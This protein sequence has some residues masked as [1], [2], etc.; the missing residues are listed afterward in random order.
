MKI[1]NPTNLFNLGRAFV[2][3]NRP[4]L[5]LGASVV[6]T[7][8]GVLLAAVGGYK[9]GYDIAERDIKLQ[10]VGEEKLDR[11]TIA[12]LTWMNYLPA[13]GLTASALGSTVGLHVIHVKEKKQL[14]TMALMA[15]E[16]VRNDAANYKQEVLESVG[17]SPSEDTKDLDKATKKSGIA[18]AVNRSGELEEMF[19]VRDR[20][21]GR[22]I[23]SNRLRIEDAINNVNR[24]L[25]RNEAVDLN[26]FYGYA[27][28]ESIPDGDELGWNPGVDVEVK[29]IKESDIRDDGRPSRPFRL[30][31]EP[32]DNYDAAH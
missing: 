24:Q 25:A 19:L 11:K 13:A 30:D 15:V 6:S 22:D 21:S 27:G 12:Q 9:S 1:P 3:A 16:Q 18:K 26:T 17:L 8:S 32:E 10:V 14:A 7:V 2:T 29:W 4:E 28:F 23:F 20:K 31:P 5:L